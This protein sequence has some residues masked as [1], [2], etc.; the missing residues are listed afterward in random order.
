MFMSI[1]WMLIWAVTLFSTYQSVT[2]IALVMCNK[3]AISY[4]KT[5]KAHE[6]IAGFAW[7]LIIVFWMN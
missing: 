3:G 5:A 6:F 1:L 2:Y 4:A 7:A